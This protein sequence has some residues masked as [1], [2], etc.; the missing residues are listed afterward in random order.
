MRFEG[1]VLHET[2]PEYIGHGRSAHG[3]SGMTRVRLLNCVYGEK[4]NGVNAQL[5]ELRLFERFVL[6]AYCGMTVQGISPPEFE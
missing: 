6:R 3:H 5:V 4:P 1:I 2:R